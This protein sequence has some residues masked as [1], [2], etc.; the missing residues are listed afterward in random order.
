LWIFLND[1][2]VSVVEDRADST[3]LVVR[4]RRAGD[5]ER[6]V[7]GC[8][9]AELRVVQTDHADYRFRTSVPRRVVARALEAAALSLD[10]PNFKDSVDDDERHAIYSRVW[11]A[12]LSLDE[13]R[14]RRY[15]DEATGDLF[16]DREETEDGRD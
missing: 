14:G 15:F 7:E 10:Y 13:R 16:D 11:S 1:A 5:V 6:F 2:F 12:A 4:A 9:A 8:M 3:M